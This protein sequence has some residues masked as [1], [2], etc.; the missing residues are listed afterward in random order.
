MSAK[1]EAT[2]ASPVVVEFAEGVGD[3]VAVEQ[4]NGGVAPDSMLVGVGDTDGDQVGDLPLEEELAPEAQSVDLTMAMA[5]GA[6]E[7]AEAVDE[8]GGGAQAL[9]NG[10]PNRL[11]DEA[12]EGQELEVG[13]DEH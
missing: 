13:A 1:T 8:A 7:Q 6:Q 5:L 11:D 3:S 4:P 10:A 12:D 2:M 9:K